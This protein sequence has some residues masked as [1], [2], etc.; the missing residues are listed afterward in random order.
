MESDRERGR[1][2]QG[3]LDGD[4]KRTHTHTHTHKHT[5][6]ETHT[7]E[8]VRERGGRERCRMH[9]TKSA[10]SRVRGSEGDGAFGSNLMAC[11]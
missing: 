1:E 11:L 8:R 9:S 7:S 6:T 4:F 5:H 3:W 2:R 10:K